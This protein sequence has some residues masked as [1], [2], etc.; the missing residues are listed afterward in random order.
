VT[1]KN[2]VKH[3]K[4]IDVITV[5]R[6]VAWKNVDLLIEA[7]N[8]YGFSLCVVGDGPEQYNLSLLAKSNPKIDI[9]GRLSQSEVDELLFSS[10]VFVLISDYEG[11]SFSL[12]QAMSFG[13]PVVVSN[14]SGNAE[15][16]KKSG[17]GIIVD[18]RAIGQLGLAILGLLEKN[19]EM[20]KFSDKSVAS[21][22]EFYNI[23][24]CLEKTTQTLAY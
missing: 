7:A 5:S 15:V 10:K 19:D 4:P 2:L 6:L 23:D 12:L 18:P 16:V 14:S 17:N 3:K 1:I 20:E 22:H 11:L 9:R 21:I 24:I 8:R 13:L